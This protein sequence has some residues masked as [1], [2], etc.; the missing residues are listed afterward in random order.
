[1]ASGAWKMSSMDP[2]MGNPRSEQELSQVSQLFEEKVREL[3]AV[4][5]IWEA[6]KSPRDIQT[7]L[8]TIID[9]IADETNAERCSLEVVS[10]GAGDLTLKAVRGALE[11]PGQDLFVER[12]IV[13]FAVRQGEPISVP[14]IAASYPG[15][16]P[17]S[18][19]CVPLSLGNK[20]VGVVNLRHS[21]PQA[22]GAE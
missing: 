18:F 21:R 15:E 19:L 14:D 20:V 9:V 12:D 1:M 7:V 11:G 13:E 2:S 10:G 22:F 16:V 8:E 3:F 4:R 5:R 17:G 6:L